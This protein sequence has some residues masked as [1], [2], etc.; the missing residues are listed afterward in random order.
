M[1]LLILLALMTGAAVMTVLWPLS[2]AVSLAGQD[3]GD[4]AFYQDQL[5][6]IERDEARGLISGPEAEAARTE[7]G[8][9]LIRVT[10][11]IPA[12]GAAMGEP[13]LRRR[14]AASAIALSIVPLVGLTVYGALGS[15]ALPGLP[16]ASRI[17]A[18][19]PNMDVET[20]IARIEAHLAQA[21]EDRRGWELVAPIY[22]RLGRF[23]DAARAFQAA[24]RLG[25]D[26]A[27]QLAA[28]G[29]A[30]VSASGGIVS[31]DARDAFERALAKEPTSPK[32]RF[33]L[34]LAAEQDGDETRARLSYAAILAAAP[35]DAPYLAVV[36][37][38][39]AGL[40][41]QPA[42]AAPSEMQPQ[43]EAMV[44]GLDARLSEK[45]GSE[46]EWARL[47]RSLVVLGRKDEARD[48]LGRAKAALAGEP[49]A[50]ERLDGLAINLSLTGEARP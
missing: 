19:P 11:S 20:A 4:V 2:R 3:R 24:I 44:G 15:P 7:A 13:A 48:R 46:A 25:S 29:E 27:E 33:Y 18:E 45:G 43:I 30:L 40:D 21:P 34:A 38:R 36:R 37:A 35:S 17:S 28:Y 50:A 42:A 41:G 5:A 49:G 22:L 39:L 14:R 26:G 1:V 32:V 31:G 47:V 16:L 10:E 6:E 9:R 8:R 23:D 12:P